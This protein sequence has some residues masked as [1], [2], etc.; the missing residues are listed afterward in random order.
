MHRYVQDVTLVRDKPSAEKPGQ[1]LLEISIDGGRNRQPGKRKGKLSLKGSQSP[2]RREGE[3]LDF[4]DSRKVIH[5]R[6]LY[7]EIHRILMIPRQP[8]TRIRNAKDDCDRYSRCAVS[9]IVAARRRQERNGW[10][11]GAAGA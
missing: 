1:T 7:F 4:E 5:G 11:V 10:A 9:S 6:I 3:L 8:S 2:R